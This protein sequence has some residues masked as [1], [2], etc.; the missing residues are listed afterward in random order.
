MIWKALAWLIIAVVALTAISIAISILASILNFA[1]TIISLGIGLAIVGAVVIG[2]IKLYSF[3]TGSSSSTISEPA[4]TSSTALS[5]EE[6]L[7]QQYLDGEITEDE[8]E[9]AIGDLLSNKDERYVQ[10]EL[11]LLER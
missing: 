2:I 11:E 6:I 4:T 5:S 7:R 9:A 8:Y 1:I 3:V 10:E